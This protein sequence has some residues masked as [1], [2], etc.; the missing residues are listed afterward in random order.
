MGDTGL[1]TSHAF[2]ENELLDIGGTRAIM[3]SIDRQ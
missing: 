1:L 2:D 3:D